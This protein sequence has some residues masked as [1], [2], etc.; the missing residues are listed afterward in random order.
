MFVVPKAEHE[1]KIL[2]LEPRG[3]L[4]IGHK[5]GE[6]TARKRRLHLSA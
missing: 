5:G 4:T 3:V 6:R 1:V 2:L